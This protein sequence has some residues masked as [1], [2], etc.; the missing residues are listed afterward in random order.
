LF[1]AQAIEFVKAVPAARATVPLV[2]ETAPGVRPG[3]RVTSLLV[4]RS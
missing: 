4:Q 2:S 3:G 1:N